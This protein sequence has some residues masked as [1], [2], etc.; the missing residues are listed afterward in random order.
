MSGQD[1]WFHASD[2]PGAHVIMKK[3]G[4]VME[5]ARLAAV[6]SKAKG[7]LVKVTMAQG[8]DGYKPLGDPPG[9][10]ICLLKKEIDVLLK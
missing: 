5:A 2:V 9:L 3:G 6:H 7:P 1:Y 4:D 8:T 10:V